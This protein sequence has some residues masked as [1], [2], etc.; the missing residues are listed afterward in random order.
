MQ[1]ARA[2]EHE[3]GQGGQLWEKSPMESPWI[4]PHAQESGTRTRGWEGSRPLNAAE[5]KAYL[6][7]K[8]D[9]RR[10]YRKLHKEGRKAARAPPEAHPMQG[11]PATWQ[12]VYSTVPG[13]DPRPA[14]KQWRREHSKKQA[15]AAAEAAGTA[16]KKRGPE[17]QRQLEEDVRELEQQVRSK[18][19]VLAE[20]EKACVEWERKLNKVRK[21]EREDEAR[22]KAII[23]RLEKA[24]YAHGVLQGQMKSSDGY[25]TFLEIDTKEDHAKKMQTLSRSVALLGTQID[26]LKTEVR[27]LL[28]ADAE[29]QKQARLSDGAG[30]PAGSAGGTAEEDGAAGADGL[31][32]KSPASPA[33]GDG[34][35][36]PAGA[37][38]PS[39][40][41]AIG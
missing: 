35:G 12:A 1:F 13:L 15:E 2:K 26:A 31:G 10:E 3:G 14:Y 20:K 29:A 16:S 28:K 39:A 6:Q 4:E 38:A 5:L 22:S 25:F 11:L 17:E 37:A 30:P 9:K 23:R 32:A 21:V 27:V 18:K 24:S 7:E 33:D 19:A 8:P 34:S 36:A 40:P 41:D